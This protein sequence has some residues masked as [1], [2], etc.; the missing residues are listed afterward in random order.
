MNDKELLLDQLTL[1]PEDWETRLVLIEMALREGNQAEA[2]RLV[3]ASPSDRPTPPEVQIR[4]HELLTRGVPA[5]PAPISP[6]APASAS[7]AVGSYQPETSEAPQPVP[8]T[9]ESPPSSDSSELPGAPSKTFP[10]PGSDLDGGLGALLE[11]ETFS[12]PASRKPDRIGSRTDAAR[13]KRPAPS[14]D[15]EAVRQKW[16]EYDGGLDLVPLDRP[17]LLDRPNSASERLSSVSLA[18]LA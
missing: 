7:S 18:L 3:R 12:R 10:G 14:I 1:Q 8:P 17:D 6:E 15:R 4:L 5:D 13:N 9:L 2:R 16:E 11:T